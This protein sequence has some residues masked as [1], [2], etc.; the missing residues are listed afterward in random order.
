MVKTARAKEM[1]DWCGRVFGA[2]VVHDGGQVVFLSWDGESHRLAL[3]KLP[4]FVRYVF[5]FSR[6]RRKAYG[7]DHLAF[8]YHSIERLLG[9]Y[10][11]LS[12]L[13]DEIERLETSRKQIA[14]LAAGTA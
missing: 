7:I 11:R 1:I 14:Q 13:R 12:H 9:N 4:R 5:P 10:E 6:I 2:R 3:V 8:T